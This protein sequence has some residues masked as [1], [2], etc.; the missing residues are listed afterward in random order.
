[1]K[2]DKARSAWVTFPDF[3]SIARHE[4]ERFTSEDMK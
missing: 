2:Y 3:S 1:M 4:R